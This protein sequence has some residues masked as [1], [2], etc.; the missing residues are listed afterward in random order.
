MPRRQLWRP[1]VRFGRLPF[2]IW[3]LLEWILVLLP[4][5]F[6]EYDLRILGVILILIGF[7]MVLGRLLDAG[8]SPWLSL[9]YFIP[10]VGFIVCVWLLFQKS[11]LESDSLWTGEP[12]S[13][14]VQEAAEA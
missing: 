10:W 9:P 11:R 2:L 4:R 3:F 12:A 6:P 5:W 1:P 7:C 8:R 13:S 14:G